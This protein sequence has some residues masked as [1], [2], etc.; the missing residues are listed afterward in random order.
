MISIS[1]QTDY[2]CRVILHLAALPPDTRVTAQEIAKRRIIPRA[3][4]RRIVTQLGKAGLIATTR[5]SGGGFALAR[6]ASAINL[7]D[8]TQAMEGELMLNA[9]VASPHACP[10]MDK[11][12]VH[13]VWV[14]AHAQ[15]TA[16]LRQATFDKL[17][18]RT[19]AIE[20]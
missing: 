11:C 6:A 17:A 3:L 8:V 13:E 4:V 5:G 7:L 19:R 9:C 2:A 15:L 12:S 18:R 1:R 16:Q 10:L 14:D 20:R